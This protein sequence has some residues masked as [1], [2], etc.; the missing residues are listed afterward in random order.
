MSMMS[1]IGGFGNLQSGVGDALG[2]VSRANYKAGADMAMA[3]QR[4]RTHIWN[5]KKQ[6]DARLYAGE[7]AGN[8][9][10]FQGI[11]S[12]VGSIGG[13]LIGGLGKMNASNGSSGGTGTAWGMPDATGG[14]SWGSGDWRQYATDPNQYFNPGN[15]KLEPPSWTANRTGW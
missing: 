7:Q 9:A 4:A 1:P 10:Q 15:F 8:A 12:A 13:S 5:A 2:D 6:A 14:S 11:A 3:A